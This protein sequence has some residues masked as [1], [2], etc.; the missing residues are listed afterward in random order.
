ML[1]MCAGRMG[2]VFRLSALYAPAP[3]TAVRHCAALSAAA[4]AAAPLR[5]NSIRDNDGARKVKVRIGRGRGSGC[6]KTSGRGQKG[7]RARN[8]VRLGFEGGQTPLQK[9]LPKVNHFDYF[10]KEF[11]RLSVGRVQ[12]WIDTGRLDV[13]RMVTMRD[14]VTS[15]CVRRVKEGVVL[16][17]GGA[18]EAPLQIEVTEVT[19]AAAEVVLRAGGTVTLAWYNRLGLRALIKPEKWTALGLPLPRW[20]SPPPKMEKRYPDR[21]DAHLPVRIIRDMDDVAEILPAWTR[22]PH[23]R[24]KRS[25][26]V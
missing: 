7:Q 6:G 10:A 20:A 26:M 18:L 13:T 16:E 1:R 5:L 4:G 22:T 17:A 8:S 3:A 24:A 12:R 9:R 11:E 23:P 15:G 19:P 2:A 14:L 21:T 25:P